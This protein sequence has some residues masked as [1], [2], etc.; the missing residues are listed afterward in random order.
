MSSAQSL[1]MSRAILKQVLKSFVIVIPV[2]LF[3]D[4]RKLSLGRGQPPFA[5]HSNVIVALELIG[6]V[7]FFGTC[8]KVTSKNCV[9]STTEKALEGGHP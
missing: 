3:I 6:R 5:V 1:H 4:I 2:P 8:P 9:I 7:H